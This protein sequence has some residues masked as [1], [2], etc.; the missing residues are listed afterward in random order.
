MI[1]M[2]SCLVAGGMLVTQRHP[3]LAAHCGQSPP[4]ALVWLVSPILGHIDLILGLRGQHPLG[5]GHQG[6]HLCC[7]GLLPA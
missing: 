5:I 2:L 6:L 1:C 4:A 7:R 3:P